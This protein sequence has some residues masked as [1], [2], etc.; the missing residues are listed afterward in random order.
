MAK[1]NTYKDLI[2]TNHAYHRL[3][4]RSLSFDGVWQTVHYPNKKNKSGSNFKFVKVIGD[5]NYQVVA[6][7]LKSENKYLIVSVWVRGEDDHAPLVWQ[8]L[9]LPFR[10]LWWLLKWLSKLIF[11][12]QKLQ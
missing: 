8:I 12:S 3:K 1:Q 11:S 9:T 7:F 10:L 2:F 4:Q 5:R 6:N